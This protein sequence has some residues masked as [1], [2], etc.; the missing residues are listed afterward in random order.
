MRFFLKCWVGVTPCGWAWLPLS[1]LNDIRP[2]CVLYP[3]CHHVCSPLTLTAPSPSPALQGRAAVG[4][5]GAAPARKPAAP[6][7]PCAG[8][9]AAHA[10][11]SRH[12]RQR[13]A[14]RRESGR[15]AG[16]PRLRCGV[17]PREL[18]HGALRQQTQ[19]EGASGRECVGPGG[20]GAGGGLSRG[21]SEAPAPED[22]RGC[23][24]A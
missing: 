6:A 16:F 8:D 19:A 12:G 4:D 21:R 17:G 14:G 10:C 2:M 18:T 23:G 11:A 1:S 15:S 13:A 22:P 24:R 20:A 9:A 3:R 7:R 5:S